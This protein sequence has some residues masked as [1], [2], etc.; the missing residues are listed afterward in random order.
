[1]P[2][3]EIKELIPASA[4]SVFALV[5]DYQR[6]LE[7]DTLLSEAYLETEFSEAK[8]GAI[9]FC[10]GKIMLGGFALRTQYVSFEKGK[11]AAVKLLNQPPFFETFAASI[12]HRAIDANHSEIIYKVNF[13]AKPRIL[14]PIL[15]PMMRFILKWE[16]RK[17]LKALKKF[18]Q[19]HTDFSKNVLA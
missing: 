11:V 14:R 2:T 13:T 19:I 3:V 7:W 12:R 10:R 4:E 6:R 18:F 16:T 15:H 9:S 8:R 1:M 5:H 17:R